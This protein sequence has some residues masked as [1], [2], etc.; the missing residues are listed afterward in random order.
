MISFIEKCRNYFQTACISI[1]L[2][3]SFMLDDCVDKPCSGAGDCDI[4]IEN[5]NRCNCNE[6]LTFDD[7][8][9]CVGEY[10]SFI[11]IG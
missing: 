7:D 8:Y 9:N 6:P 10:E 1:H 5:S 3:G 4:A 2:L 11:H